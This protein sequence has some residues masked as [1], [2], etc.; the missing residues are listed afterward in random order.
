MDW[1]GS[2]QTK[3]TFSNAIKILDDGRTYPNYFENLF[4]AQ[5]R[6][7]QKVNWLTQV[8]IC[9]KIKDNWIAENLFNFS[10]KPTPFESWYP[11]A[12]FAVLFTNF[13]LQKPLQKNSDFCAWGTSPRESGLHNTRIW[14]VEKEIFRF[15]E[16]FLLKYSYYQLSTAP[17]PGVW[18][19]FS[20]ERLLNWMEGE[21]HFSKDLF[22]FV[23]CSGFFFEEGVFFPISEVFM[24]WAGPRPS[25]ETP[26]HHRNVSITIPCGEFPLSARVINQ[27]TQQQRESESTIR[28]A[29]RN[30]VRWLMWGAKSISRFMIDL[31]VT[32]LT[33]SHLKMHD[34]GSNRGTIYST[35]TTVSVNVCQ[36]RVDPNR[37]FITRKGS[38]KTGRDFLHL[39]I[40]F[41]FAKKNSW[42][43]QERMWDDTGGG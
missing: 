7:Y 22:L 13:Q 6:R 19:F 10:I 42:M 14:V 31:F 35:T 26:L 28:R 1:F 32:N 40:G 5:P 8:E 2:K 27:S 20:Q 3:W 23:F 11:C 4:Q 15:Y 9:S 43:K 17:P 24:N 38:A 16:R 30:T 21:V 33:V 41:A 18:S 29:K 34:L 36:S 39:T 25:T 12:T 37:P